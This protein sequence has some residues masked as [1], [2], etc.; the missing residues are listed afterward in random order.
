MCVYAHGGRDGGR[1]G[2]RKEGRERERERE[3]RREGERESATRESQVS[4]ER[5]SD[6]ITRID[7]DSAQCPRHCKAVT[8][9]NIPATQATLRRY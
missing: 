1:E 2:G 5:G 3:R 8:Q 9:P 4:D 7:I 6:S